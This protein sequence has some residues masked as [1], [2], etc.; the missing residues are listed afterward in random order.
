M[1]LEAK[2]VTDRAVAYAAFHV[3]DIQSSDASLYRHLKEFECVVEP[4]WAGV[5]DLIKS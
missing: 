1:K 4:R 2:V 3:G 5:A